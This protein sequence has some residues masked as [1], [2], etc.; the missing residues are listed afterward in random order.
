MENNYT[1][2]SDE[3]KKT[4]PTSPFYDEI[5][6]MELRTYVLEE[7]KRK[8]ETVTKV[9]QKSKTKLEELKS[10]QKK[11]ELSLKLPIKNETER[12]EKERLNRIAE[13]E[14][15]FHE[16]LERSSHYDRPNYTQ[17]YFKKMKKLENERV[18][19]MTDKKIIEEILKKELLKL[20]LEKQYNHSL[21]QFTFLDSDGFTAVNFSP[22]EI[23]FAHRGLIGHLTPKELEIANNLILQLEMQLEIQVDK[24]R[25]KEEDLVSRKIYA[26]IE[27]KNAL[28]KANKKWW[29]FWK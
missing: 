3:L 21:A 28:S 25:E 14:K 27:A 9:L 22:L 24:K 13:I 15:I 19:L 29:E 10:K 4:D 26:E 17:S 23:E 2:Y 5:R 8:S 11:R 12:L 1:Q 20:K 16:D 18:S 6:K 7:S